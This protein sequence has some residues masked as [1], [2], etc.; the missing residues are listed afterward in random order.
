MQGAGLHLAS[1]CEKMQAP[2]QLQATNALEKSPEAPQTAHLAVLR[3]Y[4]QPF[5]I[6]GAL[7]GIS[8]SGHGLFRLFSLLF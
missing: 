6:Y 2:E 7:Q 8:G 4:M 1:R 3:S 5:D